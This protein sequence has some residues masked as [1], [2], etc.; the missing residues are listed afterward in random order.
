M[1]PIS[2]CMFFMFGCCLAIPLFFITA[3]PCQKRQSDSEDDQSSKSQH[4]N[5]PARSGI[6][7]PKRRLVQQHDIDTSLEDEI[8]GVAMCSVVPE[9]PVHVCTE[10]R[11]AMPMSPCFGAPPGTRRAVV[12]EAQR[13]IAGAF[14]ASSLE[15][16]LPS[17]IYDENI[18]LHQSHQDPSGALFCAMLAIR[19]D[20]SLP[21]NLPANGEMSISHRMRIAAT[22]HLCQKMYINSPPDRSNHMI[23]LLQFF[24]HEHEY[25]K[26]HTEW[27]CICTR[28][29]EVEAAILF[30][31]KIFQLAAENPLSQ[32]EAEL[33]RLMIGPRRLTNNLAL[34]I[35]GAAFFVL[36]AC[37]MSP[38][39]DVLETL[40][41]DVSTE[42]I[43][44]AVVS[45]LLTCGCAMGNPSCVY[46]HDYDSNVDHAAKV[47]TWNA[48]AAHADEL[49][50]GNYAI[51]GPPNAVRRMV[52]PDALAVA[53][54]VFGS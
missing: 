46:R 53:W 44:K 41:V 11:A 29:M 30:E 19:R 39:T 7:M 49:R 31:N 43:G 5:Q 34:T 37:L 21:T 48:C 28:Y 27:D 23:P 6:S 2:A 35:R 8:G 9:F 1:D 14:C 52:S 32:V 12:L 47:L 10:Q 25:P 36:G 20:A 22:L 38:D 15:H 16:V 33:E 13:M 26:W 18:H 3:P 42:D 24:M 45:I 54:A 50:V 51:H 17:T 40:N 4:P